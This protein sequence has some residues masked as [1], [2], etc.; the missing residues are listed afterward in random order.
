MDYYK[1]VLSTDL[2]IPEDRNLYSTTEYWMLVSF[3][4]NYYDNKNFFNKSKIILP[5]LTYPFISWINSHVFSSWNLI[6]FGSGDS[7]Q[8][9]AS[10]FNRVISFE[11]NVKYFDNI[12][13]RNLTN[14]DIQLVSK[15]ELEELD[16]TFELSDNTVIIIDSAC[17]RFKLT[18]NLILKKNPNIIVL[19]N[20]DNYRNTCSLL[21]SLHYVEIP[22]WGLK[23][24]EQFESCTSVFIRDFSKHPTPKMY[25][26]C[27]HRTIP[28]NLWD[29]NI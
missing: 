6:E 16:V 3:L 25:R 17:N 18:K 12:T 5:N 27:E 20:S 26:S 9:F 10:L 24:G 19:D 13:K 15:S 4:L 8:Y 1:K 28:N 23:Q 21:N 11:T 14:V 2:T 29:K 22:F 7:T